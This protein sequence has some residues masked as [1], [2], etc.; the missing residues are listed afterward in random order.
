L[1]SENL[2]MTALV[3]A[4][5]LVGAGGWWFEL[6]PELRVDPSRLSTLPLELEGYRGRDIAVEDTVERILEADFNLQ[7]AYQRSDDGRVV[8][9]YVG[10]YGT[11]RGGHP[12]HTPDQCYP[13]SGWE[14]ERE[15]VVEID[16][17]GDLR[18]NEFV[19]ARDAERRLVLFWYRSHQSTGML[20]RLGTSIDRLI[21]RLSVGRAD[22]ALVRIST[23]LLAS[24]EVA[25]ER[26]F[27]FARTLDPL[28][29]ARWPVEFPAGR[30]QSGAEAPSSGEEP[31]GAS[32]SEP[33]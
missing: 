18:A 8:W 33:S 14:I 9:L 30:S 6:R 27:R 15:G 2:G 16:P 24:D 11:Q 17:A 20:G 13:S 25:R 3:A 31:I 23:P 7:R 21:G 29:R 5:L 10:Y 4:M 22:G 32:G 28:L 19:V 1:T 12:E 26:L